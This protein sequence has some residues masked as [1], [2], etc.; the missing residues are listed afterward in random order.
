MGPH[1]PQTHYD[2]PSSFNISSD[3]LQSFGF[4]FSRLKICSN[5]AIK[6]LCDAG[7]LPGLNCV[8][9]DINSM[10]WE[11]TYKADYK[12]LKKYIDTKLKVSEAHG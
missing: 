11:A 2:M 9:P 10:G 1:Q 12:G 6:H 7:M 3:E 5:C 8:K 4:I